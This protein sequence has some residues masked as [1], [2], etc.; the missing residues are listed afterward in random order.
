VDQSS[1]AGGGDS[2]AYVFHAERAQPISDD[3]GGPDFFIRQFGVLV[4]VPAVGNDAGQDFVDVPSQYCPCFDNH[5]I[6]SCPRLISLPSTIPKATE[7]RES[8]IHA[9]V[10]A[11]KEASFVDLSGPFALPA[12]FDYSATFVWAITGALLA[13]RRQFDIAGITAL[14]L[15]SATGGGLLRDGIFLQNG[16][17]LVLRTWVYIA[18]VLAAASI[19]RI[20][21]SRIQRI[22]YFDRTIAAVD[23]FGLGG[24]AIVGVQLSLHAGLTIPAAA[25][26]GVVN[27]VGGGIIR[28]MM[29]QREPEIFKPG[30]PAALAALAGAIVYLGL[31]FLVGMGEALAGLI[32][33]V[34]VFALRIAA[35]RYRWYTTSV[36]N[37]DST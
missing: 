29:L 3:A 30:P 5:A 7:P 6:S 10:V 22:R 13:A 12:W 16:P 21:G 20:A 34:T 25:F 23:A 35:L 2:G 4:K 8:T 26:V 1:Y 11:D 15:V 18:L 24:F 33:V 14:A 27:A 31:V 17:P 37:F 28:D 32:A 9:S 36:R 19:V